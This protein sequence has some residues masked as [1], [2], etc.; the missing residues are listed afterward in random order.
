LTRQL[1]AHILSS[2]RL[3]LEFEETGDKTGARRNSLEKKIHAFYRDDH[4]SALFYLGTCDRDTPLTP[5]LAFWRDFAHGYIESIRL[6][7]DIE[8]LREKL[9]APADR[10]RLGK[11]AGQTPLMQGAEYITADLLEEYWDRLHGFF[12]ARIK[13][14]AGSVAEFFHEYAPDIHLVGRI[15]F[16]LVEN[17]DNEDY[18]FAFMATYAHAVN[19]RGAS[20]HRPLKY[21][22]TEYAGSSCRPGIW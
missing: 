5:A 8:R 1:Q 16:H 11:L 7:P 2:G 12:Q 17:R 22:L 15:Y 10:D 3:V 9:P 20:Q 21:A 19:A 6:N 14:F 18:P 4:L 13:S